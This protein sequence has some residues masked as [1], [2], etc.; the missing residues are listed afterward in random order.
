VTEPP[1]AAPITSPCTGV[2][3]LGNDGLC[4]GCL[5]TAT[6]IAGWIGMADVDRRRLMDD[7]LPQ[8]DRQ[9]LK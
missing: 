4:D 6:E 5:R 7:V 3:C 1:N 2:C 8:R 9:R